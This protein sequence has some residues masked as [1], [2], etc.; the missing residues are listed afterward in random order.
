[1]FNNKLF[2]MNLF[3]F[4]YIESYQCGSPDVRDPRFDQRSNRVLLVRRLFGGA[5][6]R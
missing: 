1:M 6:I 4:V 5:P 2:R 3:R